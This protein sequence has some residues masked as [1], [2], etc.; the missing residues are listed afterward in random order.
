MTLRT[1]KEIRPSEMESE[2]DFSMG[3]SQF[4]SIFVLEVNALLGYL[5]LDTS[6]LMFIWC[7]IG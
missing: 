4:Y 6:I 2:S 1:G 7:T 3:L 5:N